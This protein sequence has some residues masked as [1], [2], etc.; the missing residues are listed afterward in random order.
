MNINDMEALLDQEMEVVR[1]GVTPQVCTC[2]TGAY[3]ATSG[4]ECHCKSGALLDGGPAESCTCGQGAML[5]RGTIVDPPPGL[6]CTSGFM[7]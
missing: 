3:V 7:G 4:G 2:E 6:G 5:K 1:G